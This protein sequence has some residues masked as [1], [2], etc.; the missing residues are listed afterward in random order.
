MSEAGDREQRVARAF[1]SL[2][3]TLVDDYDVIELLTRLVD[4]SVEL[5]SADAAAIMLADPRGTLRVVAASSEDARLTELMQ[6]QAEEGPCMDCYRN[7]APVNVSDLL[8]TTDRW[9]DFVAAATAGVAMPFR[10]VHAVP[11]RLRG[12]AIGALNLFHRAPGAM[13]SRDLEL[14]QAL[15]DVSTIAILQERAVRRAEVLNEQL[16]TALTSRVIIEQAKGALAQYGG[17]SVEQAF[18]RMRTYARSH[19]QR[20]SDVARAIAGRGLDPGVVMAGERVSGA[21]PRRTSR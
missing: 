17:V 11:L 1:V 2:A 12:E 3:D 6:L 18:T 5:L 9:P 10:A 7:V 4:Y 15:A 16:Q 20:L 14:G 13:S 8:Q 19:N 21:G